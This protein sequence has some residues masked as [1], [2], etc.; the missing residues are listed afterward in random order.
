M[1]IRNR[2]CL[3]NHARCKALFLLQNADTI[4][5]GVSRIQQVGGGGEGGPN[6]FAR[7]SICEYKK[8]KIA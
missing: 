6:F 7:G 2:V 1:Y 3:Q 4:S 5:H 8:D